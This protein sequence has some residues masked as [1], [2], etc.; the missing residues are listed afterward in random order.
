MKNLLALLFLMVA[1]Q[2]FAQVRMQ[3]V[4]KDSIGSPLELANVIAIN[5]ETNSLDAYAITNDKGRYQMSL[6][7]NSKY[8]VQVSYIG[9]KTAEET[10]ETKEVEISKDFTLYADNALDAIELTY[11][12]PVTISGDTI[13]YNADSFKSGTERKLEDVLK[14]L[15]G[16]EV[17]ADGQIEVDGIRVQKLMI[18]G[19]DFFDGDTKLGV[20]NIPSNAVDKIQVLKNYAEV[21]QLSGVQNNQDNIAINIKLKEGK[22]N[23]W[24]GDV[25]AGG[26]A[27]TEN[28]L[29][30][31]QPKLF[32]YSPKYSINFIGDMNN[33][34][35][36]ALSNRDIRNFSGG[37][38]NPSRQSGT[39]ISLGN[40]NINFSAL[41]N[42]RAQDLQTKLGAA[43]FNYSPNSKLD[44]SGF[45]IFAGSRIRLQQNSSI[46]YTDESLGIP[47][48]ERSNRTRQS[49]DQGILKLSAIY[50]PNVN[51]QLDY[52]VLGRLSKEAQT[53]Q[54]FSS[55]IGNTDQIEDVTP[56]SINQN[57]NYY[58]TLND[59]N[60]FAIEAQHLLQNEDPFYNAV[61][62]DKENY[63]NTAS[64]LGFDNLQSN[65]NLAQDRRVKSNQLD[66]K[67]DYWNVLNNK[68]NINFTFG[69]ILSRQDF[70]SDMFQFLDN[71]SV[72]TPTPIINDGLNVNDTQYNFSD[73]YLGVHYTLK[74]GIFTLTPGFSAHAYGNRNVQFGEEFEDNFFR[75][76]PD[77]L[78][79]IQLK[80]SETIIFNYRMQNQFTDV[81]NLARG[82]VLNS[83]NSIFSGNEALENAL[84]HSV[85]LTYRS[86]NLFNYTNV[87]GNLSYNKSIDQIRNL[88][89]F[90][91]VITTSSPFNSAFADE[92]FTAFGRFQ[93]TFGKIR[94]TANGSF[95]YAKFNQFIQSIRSVNES[96]NQNYG[97]A[98]NSNFREAPNFTVRYNYSIRQN[99]QGSTTTTFFTN[100]PSAEF[101]ALIWKAFTFR[102]DYTYN[103]TS[104]SDRTLNTFE[105]WNASLN[106]R[107]DKNSKFEYEIR[108]TNLLN[109]QFTVSTLANNISVSVQ[110]FFIQPRFVT[111]RLRY[112]I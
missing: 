52:D 38:R 58:Y 82:L 20:Q 51:N 70:N 34:G 33:I 56:Y 24:F 66:A 10:V 69:T 90:E 109:T 96:Y 104:D 84:S 78:A 85:N 3:G 32:Y 86:F 100:A 61:L 46:V 35:E 81:T 14:K 77:F 2:T 19:K 17:N 53:D 1:G 21:G 60:I 102:T 95:N 22:K 111:F 98:V 93:R 112:N 103:R 8:K 31:F 40:N 15:P 5:I 105:I 83:F 99:D 110:E 55:I 97:L 57:F 9:M 62:E 54:L 23:F 67:L 30:L 101:D 68:S 108:A 76:L 63:E 107:K 18:D 4:V 28:E 106:Y 26:G 80:K 65:F 92:T 89:N 48:E 12:M 11:E 37:F 75:L 44:L 25:T 39:N 64:A 43:S 27:S 29:Y 41:Q 49:S 71:N 72:F 16:V 88:T 79:R 13:V 42:N 36:L 87:V 6:N 91:S 7:K 45:A 73:L 47:D 50:K 94:A 74:S 59:K